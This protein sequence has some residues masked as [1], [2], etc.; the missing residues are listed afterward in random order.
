MSDGW[1]TDVTYDTSGDDV[2]TTDD[3]KAG[4]GI[5]TPCEEPNAGPVRDDR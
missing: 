4:I 3:Y 2:N 1:E 5:Y